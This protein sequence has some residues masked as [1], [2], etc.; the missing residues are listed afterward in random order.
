MTQYQRAL[1]KSL[2]KKV[3]RDIHKL[4]PRTLFLNKKNVCKKISLKNPKTL[5]KWEENFQRQMPELQFLKWYCTPE[6]A[7]NFVF[8]TETPT[9]NMTFKKTLQVKITS[10]SKVIPAIVFWLWRRLWQ[11]I[12][13]AANFLSHFL[14]HRNKRRLTSGQ[15]GKWFVDLENWYK[16]RKIFVKCL[17]EGVKRVPLINI[18]FPNFSKQFQSNVSQPKLGTMYIF[19]GEI[20]DL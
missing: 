1:C 19:W 17:G 10:K 13:I 6:E 14:L 12:K 4:F 20:F 15:V 8:S 9:K 7:C 18:T 11:T 2:E 3:F 16:K 5:R